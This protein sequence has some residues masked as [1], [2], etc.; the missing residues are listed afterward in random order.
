M[1]RLNNLLGAQALALTDRLHGA[2]DGLG[3]PTE[4]AALVTLL[5]HD[6]CS[7][8][9]L[10]QV[11]EL[12][13]SGVTRLVS[14]LSAA[15]WVT[16]TPGDDARSRQLSLTA[17]GRRRADRVLVA[18]RGAMA[19]VVAGLTTRDKA[20]LERLLDLVVGG[21]ADDEGP[22]ALRVCRLC[23]RS[24]CS[25]GRLGCPLGHISPESASDG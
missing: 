10:G 20:Q 16:S 17:A 25:S 22:A 3:T 7:V 13:S 18:R 5:T 19:D 24:A 23:D 2:G 1:D 11:V 6:Q 9:W 21:L 12:T 14:R 15:G 4:R 8:S